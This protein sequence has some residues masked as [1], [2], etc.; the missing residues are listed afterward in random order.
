MFEGHVIHIAS[1]KSQW[2]KVLA[3]DESRVLLLLI[4]SPLMHLQMRINP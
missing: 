3:N 4:P 1:Q 2:D